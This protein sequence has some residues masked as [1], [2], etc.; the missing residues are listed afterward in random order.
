MVNGEKHD[1]HHDD[2][3]RCDKRGDQGDRKASFLH[4]TIINQLMALFEIL[5][6]KIA[7]ADGVAVHGPFFLEGLVD[8]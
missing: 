5:E 7:Q 6:L 1:G 2:D 8:A 4:E 3:G